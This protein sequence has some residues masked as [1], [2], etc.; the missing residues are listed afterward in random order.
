MEAEDQNYHEEKKH[1]QLDNDDQEQDEQQQ[2]QEYDRNDGQDQFE[3]INYIN[4]NRPAFPGAELP[5]ENHQQ[6]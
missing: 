1:Y 6:Y 3:Q 4:Q 2:D 5:L